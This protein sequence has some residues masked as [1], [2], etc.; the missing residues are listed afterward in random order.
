MNTTLK[1]IL[2]SVIACMSAGA[3]EVLKPLYG[4]EFWRTSVQ[5]TNGATFAADMGAA[6]VVADLTELAAVNPDDGAHTVFV[7]DSATGGTFVYQLDGI[8]SVDAVVNGTFDSESSWTI[9]KKP[10]TFIVDDGSTGYTNGPVTIILPSGTNITATAQVHTT[11]A[12]TNLVWTGG[13]YTLAS[14]TNTATV[15]QGIVVTGTA[16]VWTDA[17]STWAIAGGNARNTAP[18]AAITEMYQSVPLPN[19]PLLDTVRVRGTASLV[20]VGSLVVKL[21][22]QTIGTITSNGAFEFDALP[23]ATTELLR[24]V[25]SST[26]VGTIDD[27]ILT[28]ETANGSTIVLSDVLGFW[29]KRTL[30]VVPTYTDLVSLGTD[31]PVVVRTRGH[32]TI[33]DG[34]GD[35]WIQFPSSTYTAD[36]GVV[37]DGDGCQWVRA[38]WLKGEPVQL[39][40]YGP[41]ADGVTSDRTYFYRAMTNVMAGSKILQLGAKTYAVGGSSSVL[42]IDLTN[43]HNGLIIQGVGTNSVINAGLAGGSAAPDAIFKPWD[44]GQI[45]FRDLCFDGSGTTVPPATAG[46]S[47]IAPYGANDILVE[48]C[49]F[50][51]LH[52]KGIV[53]YG[54]GTMTVRDCE[55]TGEMYAANSAGIYSASTDVDLLVENNYFHDFGG[56]RWFIDLVGNAADGNTI[57]CSGETT[58]TFRTVVATPETEILIG[59]TAGETEE[60]IQ[61]HFI[62]YPFSQGI[63]TG[64]YPPARPTFTF[65]TPVTMACNVAGAACSRTQPAQ[66]I[67]PTYFKSFL[68]RNNRFIRTGPAATIR[69][70][71]GV[72]RDNYFENDSKMDT[73]DQLS[74]NVS[75]SWDGYHIV[76][77]ARIHI[78]GNTVVENRASAFASIGNASNYVIANN[79]VLRPMEETNTY[80]SSSRFIYLGGGATNCVVA[81][82]VFQPTLNDRGVLSSFIYTTTTNCYANMIGPNTLI[83]VDVVVQSKSA[84]YQQAGG[85]YLVGA[86][87]LMGK[88]TSGAPYSQIWAV[89][90]SGVTNT[91]MP[92]IVLEN[93]SGASYPLWQVRSY[94]PTNT[95]VT[96]HRSVWLNPLD[97]SKWENFTNAIANQVYGTPSWWVGSLYGTGDPNGSY[98]INQGS[99]FLDRNTG[100]VWLKTST[101]AVNTGWVPYDYAPW[102]QPQAITSVA[103]VF[104]IGAAIRS[105]EVNPDADRTLTSALPDGVE[106]QE[107]TF[108]CD[109]SEANK[110]TL[111][112]EATLAGSNLKCGT[113]FTN[114][115][116]RAFNPAKLVFTGGSWSVMSGERNV[117]P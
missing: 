29:H 4:T 100:Q 117:E 12:I 82:N 86:N 13:V 32:I 24:F 75:A 52:D 40:W 7:S 84:F 60:S 31:A 16:H 62:A 65:R 57:T 15:V 98:S 114:V 110:V 48:R 104:T 18:L 56:W 26:F 113:G 20:T 96:T 116:F 5:T 34:L 61:A 9:Q 39:D 49:L 95:T 105:I 35:D 43:W 69:L 3:A 99:T 58:R 66:C 97:G 19:T 42:R 28:Q 109:D 71:N 8:T 81:N 38:S 106:G 72:F 30:S 73:D 14:D 92:G 79:I 93:T 111:T 47:I 115:V 50:R 44:A 21:G 77:P 55:W 90:S 94:S 36:N 37:V 23:T 11:T 10:K 102:P 51:N 54:S 41:N 2:A 70:S 74:F 87:K 27:V 91:V 64:Y 107:V 88:Y 67:Y 1:L 112:D 78:T 85:F 76:P 17:E 80:S 53:T 63:T 59:G 68:A 6:I 103:S 83:N 33:T 45:T 101:S 89:G 25:P 108:Y 22:S 46:K